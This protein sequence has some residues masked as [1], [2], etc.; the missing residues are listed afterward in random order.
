MAK[1]FRR[2]TKGVITLRHVLNG[3]RTLFNQLFMRTLGQKLYEESKGQ[4]IERYHTRK[5][6]HCT[7]NG[8]GQK[9][10]YIGGCHRPMS[11]IKN[12]L[13]SVADENTFL[14]V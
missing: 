2:I 7:K 4:T 10:R 11:Y 13:S 12:V 5:R 1:I 6:Y 14:G 3:G 8:L 9:T